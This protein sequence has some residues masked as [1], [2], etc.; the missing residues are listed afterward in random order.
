[1]D[2]YLGQMAK[3]KFP[4]LTK[5]PW[6][7]ASECQTLWNMDTALEKEDSSTPPLCDELDDYCNLRVCDTLKMLAKEN[8]EEEETLIIIG[9]QS[10]H[11]VFHVLHVNDNQ[12]YPFELSRW[13]K[14]IHPT[15]VS[16]FIYCPETK[17]F[18]AGFSNCIN[19]FF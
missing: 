3:Q 11:R 7:T 5:V 17:T 18:S 12:N 13:D 2:G 15:A 8:E 9:H 10:T 6:F 19:H 14:N 16:E 4:S 1:M